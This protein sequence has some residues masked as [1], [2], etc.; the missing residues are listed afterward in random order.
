MLSVLVLCFV[1]LLFGVFSPTDSLRRK[2]SFLVI[3]QSGDPS[4]LGLLSPP[5][6]SPQQAAV[7]C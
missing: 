5:S 6:S 1:G 3:S 7:V 2:E 4:A